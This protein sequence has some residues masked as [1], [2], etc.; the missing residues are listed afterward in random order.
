M[1]TP[2]VVV[3][4]CAHGLAVARALARD[5]VVVYAVDSRRDLP[6]LRTKSA[7]PV[8]IPSLVGAALV[9]G[10]LELQRSRFPDARPVLFLTNDRMVETVAEHWPRLASSFTLSWGMEA[11][12]SLVGRLLGKDALPDAF[13][14]ADITA[15]RTA[16]LDALCDIDAVV[17]QI[18]FPLIAK[19][20]QPL[21]GFKAVRVDSRE[22]LVQL[23]RT[24]AASLPFVLQSWINGGDDRIHF[25]AF[26]LD[27]GKPVAAFAG[28]KVHSRPMGH[29]CIAQAWPDADVIRLG[30]RFFERHP[31]SGA[32]SLEL[33]RAPDGS[34]LAIEPTVGRTDFWVDLAVRNGVNLPM[35]EYRVALGLSPQTCVPSSR[36]LWIN[37]ERD[38]FAL[39]RLLVRAPRALVT[40]RP[41]FLY[42]RRGDHGPFRSATAEAMTALGRRMKRFPMRWRRRALEK[43]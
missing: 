27:R 1:K 25:A 32:V 7:T 35:A 36:A 18:G 6:G 28:R 10:L 8:W 13:A 5:G 3:G 17:P 22:A 43:V 41:V 15:P 29:T 2:A 11:Q 31:V 34:L 23:A 37:H 12:R 21:S 42:W 39:P 9:D 33:K 30:E 19:P 16:R 4:L 14:A 26:V 40:R 38:P 20:T 24:H